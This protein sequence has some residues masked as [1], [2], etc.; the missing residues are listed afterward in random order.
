MIHFVKIEII[1]KC[2][3]T[4]IGICFISEKSMGLEFILLSV[5]NK[6]FDLVILS[7]FIPGS[8]NILNCFGSIVSSL[9]R[10]LRI[11][12]FLVQAYDDIFAECS[13]LLWV[14]NDKLMIARGQKCGI[15]I[16]I[17]VLDVAVKKI[18]LIYRGDIYQFIIVYL[19][20]KNFVPTINSVI[21]VNLVHHVIRIKLI[22]LNDRFLYK[23]RMKLTLGKFAAM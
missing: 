11:K 22:K 10:K 3:E 8:P 4:F 20:V 18:G 19:I 16:K 23:F 6:T 14:I 17:S 12:I 15:A 7:V 13:F 9:E 1:S 2:V 5:R 21:Y